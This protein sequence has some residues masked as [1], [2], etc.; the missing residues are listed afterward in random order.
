MSRQLQEANIDKI[1]DRRG[2]KLIEARL[3]AARGSIREA[4][5]KAKITIVEAQ[6]QQ[7][8]TIENMAKYRIDSML[9]GVIQRIEDLDAATAQLSAIVGQETERVEQMAA[10]A[11]MGELMSLAKLGTLERI[12]NVQQMA[13]V[14]RNTL[15]AEK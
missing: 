12:G 9:T 2:R 15:A 3:D 13:S 14:G 5:A 10:T 7:V 8:E 1:F 6:M 11:E 4:A